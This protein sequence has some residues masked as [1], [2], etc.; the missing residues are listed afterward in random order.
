MDNGFNHHW[1]GDLGLGDIVILYDEDLDKEVFLYVTDYIQSPNEEDGLKI[2][3][4]NKKYKDKDLRTIADKLKEGR[5]AM[6][7]IQRKSYLMNEQ[8]YK[9][10][11]M[12]D[13]E[14][15]YL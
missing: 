14:R 10:I 4:S 2:T 6:R 3:L 9:R 5:L 13:Y 7:T 1:K 8:K 15:N 12:K 11:N